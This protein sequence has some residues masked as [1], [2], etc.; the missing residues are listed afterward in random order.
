M[1]LARS[2]D[3]SQRFYS[4]SAQ[5]RTERNRYYAMLEATQKGDLDVALWPRWFLEY[6]KRALSCLLVEAS[7]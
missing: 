5:I 3:S 7:L 1:A 6:L 2:E 4:L